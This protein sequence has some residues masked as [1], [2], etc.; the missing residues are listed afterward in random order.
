MDFAQFQ[1]RYIESAA[2]HE[3]GH[4]TAA[5]VQKMP[6]Q[7]QGVHIDVKGSGI[8]YYW[9]RRPGDPQNTE[10]DR[11]ERELTIVAIYAGQAIQQRV[12]PDCPE[13][14]WADDGPEISLLL[15]EMNLPDLKTRTAVEATLWE[16]ASKLVTEHWSL[17]ES[18]VQALLAKPTT[19]QPSIEIQ[20]NWS[21]GQTNLEKW[22]NGSEI[23]NF[24]PCAGD[25]RGNIPSRPRH[26]YVPLQME[27][28]YLCYASKWA[29]DFAKLLLL[30]A[31]T[32][33]E[34]VVRISV[35]ERCSGRQS[36]RTWDH[37][38]KLESSM[39][40]SDVKVNRAAIALFA[41]CLAFVHS[42]GGQDRFES[43]CDS[44]RNA[45]SPDLLQ[46]LNGVVPDERNAHC[47]TWAIH[48]LGEDHYEPA[49]T[50]LVKLLD[51]RRPETRD[52][53]MGIYERPQIIEELFPAANALEV[54]GKNALPEVLRAI[55][56]ASTLR[57]GAGERRLGLDGGIQI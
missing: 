43:W 29:A 56:A 9:H 18:L 25:V 35:R 26:K 41:L 28:L 52:E 50:V 12:F 51:F 44:L 8:S 20:R 38:S 31:L 33:Y 13:T 46:F 24:V 32:L 17:I 11:V 15:D 42:A 22:M 27:F 14:N 16:R 53:K 1:A 19:L 7:E 47:V 3:V 37:E 4:V 55:E 21:H 39:M 48:K 40:R 34:N 2:Y 57:D 23:V 6:L 10:Q 45:S 54:I 30:R 36:D 49:I 5:V